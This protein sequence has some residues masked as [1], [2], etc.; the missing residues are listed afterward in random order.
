MTIHDDNI[1]DLAP[2][3]PASDEEQATAE[4]FADLVDSLLMDDRLPDIMGA[5]QRELIDTAAIMR[6]NLRDHALPPVRVNAL[7]DD[8]LAR[9]ADD[10]NAGVSRRSPEVANDVGRRADVADVIDLSARRRRLQRLIPWG[11]ATFAAAAAL[12]FALRTSPPAESPPTVPDQLSMMH[13]SRPADPLIGQIPR[14]EAGRAST[15][16]DTI[17]SDRMAGYRDLRLRGATR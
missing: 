16:L 4:S 7:I 10:A 15:R 6:A 13:R 9:A 11:V 1:D 5:E 14:A 17:Y 12:I 3:Q 2:E 8:A